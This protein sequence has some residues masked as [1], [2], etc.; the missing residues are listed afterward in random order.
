MFPPL[1]E[2]SGR[3]DLKGRFLFRPPFRCCR[4]WQMRHRCVSDN[5]RCKQG[6]VD[7]RAV[8]RM[9]GGVRGGGGKLLPQLPTEARNFLDA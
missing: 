1:P 2:L 9:D 4:P 8:G 3:M 7:V 6:R 5:A